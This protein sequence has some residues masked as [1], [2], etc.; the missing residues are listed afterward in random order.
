MTDDIYIENKKIL[1]DHGYQ[2]LIDIQGYLNRK[3]GKVFMPSFIQDRNI[4]EALNE[5][6]NPKIWKIYNTS[7]GIDLDK[8]LSII[9]RTPL[10]IPN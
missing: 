8:V 3:A 1:E 6:H 4:T 5:I 7:K 10:D 9:G 2:Y